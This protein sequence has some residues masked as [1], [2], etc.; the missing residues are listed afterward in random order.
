MLSTPEILNFTP[1]N[2][3]GL[4]EMGPHFEVIGCFL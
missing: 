1:L 2:E 4:L 3:V